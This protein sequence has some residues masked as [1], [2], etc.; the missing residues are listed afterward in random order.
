METPTFAQLKKAYLD[1]G[2]EIRVI[3]RRQLEGMALDAPAE[4]KRHLDTNIMGLIIPDENAIGIAADLSP[5]ERAVT[6]LHEWIHLWDAEV[7]E[8][9]VE[10][11]TL[12]MEETITPNQFGFLQFLVS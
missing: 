1:S 7:E 2:Y 10:I 9:D 4:V 11:M 5:E 6:L 3:P 8:D 12:E